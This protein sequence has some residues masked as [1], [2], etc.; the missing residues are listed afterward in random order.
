MNTTEIAPS[1]VTLLSEIA[2]GAPRGGSA[3]VLNGGDPGLLASLDELSAEQ[4]SRSRDGGATIA[5]HVDHVRYG[6]SLMNRW[7]A[8]ENPFPEADWSAAWR[9]TAVDDARWAELRRAL[10]DEVERWRAALHAP[11]EVGPVEL[12]GMI[13]SIV[14]LAYH[15]GAVRQIVPDLRGPK[16]ASR[17]EASRA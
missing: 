11:R 8:G 3:Y 5:A 9:T 14:H 10:R 15:L 13:A 2:L 16:E 6:L 1:L 7:A 4:A 12:E 17:P